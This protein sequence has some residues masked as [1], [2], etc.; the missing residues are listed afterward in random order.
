MNFSDATNKI[1]VI[2]SDQD[3]QPS[4]RDVLVALGAL[5]QAMEEE[6][7]FMRQQLQQLAYQTQNLR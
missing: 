2:L 7:R 4:N 6:S 3:A 5:A 1:R